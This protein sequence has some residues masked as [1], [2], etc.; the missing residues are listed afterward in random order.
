MSSSLELFLGRLR[1][2]RWIPHISS[3]CDHRCERCAFSTRCWSYALIQHEAG[4]ADLATPVADEKADVDR[5]AATRHHSPAERHD[6]DL[7]DLTMTPSET[8]AYEQLQERIDSDPLRKRA[9][10]YG[11]DISRVMKSLVPADRAGGFGG[12]AAGSDVSN[13]VEDIWS[14]ALTIGAKTHRAISSPT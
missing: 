11:T 6:I 5:E 10:E 12:A 13:A 2:P 1:D 7:N 9:R 14:L 4:A 3:Y 8:R